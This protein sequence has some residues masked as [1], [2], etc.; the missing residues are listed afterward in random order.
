MRLSQVLVN[1]RAN[2][3]TAILNQPSTLNALTT[4]MVFLKLLSSNVLVQYS[5]LITCFGFVYG[6][7]HNLTG[8][9]VEKTV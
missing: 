5:V 3:R 8:G 6:D 1:G 7:E 4:S 2:S 9:K